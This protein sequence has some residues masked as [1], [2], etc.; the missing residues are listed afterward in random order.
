MAKSPF[1][2]VDVGGRFFKMCKATVLKYPTSLLAQVL[3]TDDSISTRNQSNSLF[4]DRN[5]DYFCI[6]VDFMRTGKAFVPASLDLEQFKEEAEFWGLPEAVTVAKTESLK[7]KR[8]E[9]ASQEKRPKLQLKSLEELQTDLTQIQISLAQLIS[10]RTPTLKVAALIQGFSTVEQKAISKLVK[11]LNGK[12]VDSFSEEPSHVIVQTFDK[13]TMQLIAINKGLELV[14]K[15]WVTDSKMA[16]Y[17]L[18]PQNYYACKEA[19]ERGDFTFSYRASLDKAKRRRCFADCQFVKTAFCCLRFPAGYDLVV[20]SAG[21]RFLDKLPTDRPPK[22][23]I[24]GDISLKEATDLAA[25]GYKV[26]N[27]EWVVKCVL[28]Q[29]II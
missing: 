13:T 18:P 1:V 3:E 26:R 12:V 7:R 24:L 16:G 15:S 4:F 2:C 27:W 17:W 10:Q 22:L 14:T 28:R 23:V 25:V 20:V 5:P 21:G 6:L 19:E 11:D 29:E 9:Q 8:A